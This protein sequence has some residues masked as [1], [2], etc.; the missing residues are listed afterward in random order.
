MFVWEMFGDYLKST[1]RGLSDGG[2]K[3]RNLSIGRRETD[4]KNFNQSDSKDNSIV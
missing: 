1:E 2:M 3:V 4:V